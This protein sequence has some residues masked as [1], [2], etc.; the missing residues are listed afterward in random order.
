MPK[1]LHR[2]LI[3]AADAEGKA[4]PVEGRASLTVSG[5]RM[6]EGQAKLLVGDLA[7]EPTSIVELR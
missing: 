3:S 5:V 1:G 6:E 2:Y 4:V 7:I